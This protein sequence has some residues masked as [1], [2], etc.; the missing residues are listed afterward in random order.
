MNDVEFFAVTLL[1]R[2][3]L[4]GLQLKGSIGTMAFR[5]SGALASGF[6][7]TNLVKIVEILER[8]HH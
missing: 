6:P 5:L 2:R 3:V 8:L 7:N 1:L 4:V